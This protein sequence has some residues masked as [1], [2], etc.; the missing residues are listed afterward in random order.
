MSLFEVADAGTRFGHRSNAVGHSD[1]VVMVVIAGGSEAE[2]S[3]AAEEQEQERCV[4]MARVSNFRGRNGA[5]AHQHAM[6]VVCALLLLPYNG[7][8][9]VLAAILAGADN[10]NCFKQA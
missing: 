10:R 9:Q 6:M 7:W 2:Q 5:L 8:Q 3:A 4:C 1:D